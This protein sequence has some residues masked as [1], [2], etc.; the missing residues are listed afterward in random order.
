LHKFRKETPLQAHQNTQ[1]KQVWE[2]SMVDYSTP[3][4]PED[5]KDD[6]NL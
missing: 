2:H 3:E 1:L 4:F 5:N 6:V